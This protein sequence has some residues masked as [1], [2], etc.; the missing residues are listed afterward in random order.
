M[1]NTDKLQQVFQRVFDNPPASLEGVSRENFAEWDSIH[2]LSLVL[3]LETE[4]GVKLNIEQI[5]SIK[6]VQDIL[7][8]IG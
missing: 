5:E 7:N 8:N 2:H 1:S 4:F 6:S 3:E